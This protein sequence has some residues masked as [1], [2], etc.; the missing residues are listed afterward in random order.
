MFVD[1][2]ITV[3]ILDHSDGWELAKDVKYYIGNSPI[4]LP[5]GFK[6]DFASIPTMFQNIIKVNGKHRKAALLH[7]YLYS[8]N[9]SV[10]WNKLTREQCDVLFLKEME[11]ANVKWLKRKVMYRMVRWCGGKAWD[12]C[13]QEN[14]T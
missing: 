10:G 1:K 9:G 6:T 5:K 13:E 3:N 7:D 4:T 14:R 8:I 11:R 12:K 2:V